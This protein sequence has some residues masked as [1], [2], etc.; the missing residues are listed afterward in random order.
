MQNTLPCPRCDEKFPTTTGVTEHIKIAH[1]KKTDV[2]VLRS[3]AESKV[4]VLR[5]DDGTFQCPNDGCPYG[6]KHPTRLQDHT[7][8][9]KPLKAKEPVVG[10]A[11]SYGNAQ[12]VPLGDDIERGFGFFPY[13][14]PSAAN[15]LQVY[16]FDRH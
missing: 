10:Q 2:T 5:S 16:P 8:T 12:I 7:K 4:T 13:Y 6:H 11:D 1:Q 3:G 9:C 14:N 15:S